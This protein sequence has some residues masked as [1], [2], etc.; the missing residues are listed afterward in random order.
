MVT[1]VRHYFPSHHHVQNHDSLKQMIQ[2]I[3]FREKN[4][5]ESPILNMGKYMGF[6]VKI[7]PE[8]NHGASG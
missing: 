7:F 3:D 5:S 1:T 6:P 8:T 4:T 2:C